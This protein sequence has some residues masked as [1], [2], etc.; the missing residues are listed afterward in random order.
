[1]RRMIVIVAVLLVAGPARTANPGDGPPRGS[2]S[3]LRTAATEYADQVLSLVKWVEQNYVRSVSR[4]DLAEAALEG[5]YEAAREPM[6]A[7]LRS[8]LALANNDRQFLHLVAAAR[9]RLGDVEALRG[10]GAVLASLRSLPRALDP[11]CGLPGLSDRR[12]RPEVMH[13][14]GLEFESLPD[15]L[16]SKPRRYPD[17][18][19]DVYQSSESPL[20]R[21]PARIAGVVPGSPAQRAGVLPGDMLTLL[22]GRALDAPESIE[23][24]PRLYKAGGRDPLRLTLQRPGAAGPLT[25]LVTPSDFEPESVYGVRRRTDNSWDFVLDPENKIGYAR[26]GQIDEGSVNQMKRAVD[27]LRSIGMRGLVFDLRGNPGGF[28]APAQEIS[29]MFVKSGVVATFHE[30]D[31]DDD[32]NKGPRQTKPRTVSVENPSGVLKGIPT[33]VLV[34]GETRGGGEMIAAALQDHRVARVAGERSFGK[35]SVQ[36]SNL[37]MPGKLPPVD[38]KLTTG[39]FTRANGRN[40]NRFPDSKPSDDWGIV[41]DAGLEFPITPELGLQIKE[42]MM[43]Q[44]LRPGDSREPLP[45]DDPANDPPREFAR[46]VLVRKLK[47]IAACA[48]AGRLC[49]AASGCA[50]SPGFAHASALSIGCGFSP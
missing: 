20:P 13:G 23:S 9:E 8:E 5:L 49:E 47:V 18:N 17:T 44:A 10:P 31:S 2:T 19:D 21:G 36:R 15:A 35:G 6:P 43:R 14:I 34:D 41:P 7:S 24:Y 39:T 1:M 3:S 11:F 27:E 37:R 12:D 50:G 48:F 33:I 42:W 26:L 38:F 29:G 16:R 40:L 22:N 25:V 32:T 46:Q 4:A 45:L 28:V 30:I